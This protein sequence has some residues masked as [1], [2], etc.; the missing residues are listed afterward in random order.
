MR[1]KWK[2]F[3]FEF[4][5]EPLRE[6]V[7]QILKVLYICTRRPAIVLIDYTTTIPIRKGHAN[8]DSESSIY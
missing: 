2:V 5:Y 3:L 1:Q 6:G 4:Q 8:I 7:L